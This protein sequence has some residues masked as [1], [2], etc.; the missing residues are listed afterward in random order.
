[1]QKWSKMLHNF[2]KH[3]LHQT[4]LVSCFDK[5]IDFLDKRN[6]EDLI[7]CRKVFVTVPCGKLLSQDKY[8]NSKTG[9]GDFH[10]F[11]PK[12]EALV[13]EKTMVTSQDWPDVE[14]KECADK[15]AQHAKLRDI[16]N[17][18]DNQC[19][20]W[21]EWGTSK[22]Q[23]PW[24]SCSVP[25]TWEVGEWTL[26]DKP[27]V[28]CTWMEHMKDL[29]KSVAIM[30]FKAGRDNGHLKLFPVNSWKTSYLVEFPDAIQF[31][32]S[33]VLFSNISSNKQ[34]LWS[35]LTCVQK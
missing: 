6:E 5:I 20:V 12:D 26:W 30:D 33:V 2:T 29:M 19:S 35:L 25:L 4:K 3:R 27:H 31:W 16:I 9:E 23:V 34:L 17:T 14:D 15:L 13:W 24:K 22:K 18:E 32:F 7:S 28:S 11:M 21:G 10:L 8:L 1:M